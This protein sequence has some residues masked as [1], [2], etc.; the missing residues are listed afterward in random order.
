MDEGGARLGAGIARHEGAIPSEGARDQPRQVGSQGLDPVLGVD[1][2][3]RVVDPR[4]RP[5]QPSSFVASQPLSP[6]RLTTA[7]S[8]AVM[9][10]SSEEHTSEPQSLMRISYAVFCLK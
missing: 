5:Y 6:S 10:R 4:R 2:G 9:M 3:I 7:D 8:S 1:G